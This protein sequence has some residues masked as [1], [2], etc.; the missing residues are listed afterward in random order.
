MITHQI[1]WQGVQDEAVEIL[2]KYIRIN[3]TNPP[4]NEMEAA[5][6]LK[7]IF[8]KEGGEAFLYEPAPHRANLM[9]VIPG[10]MEGRP[11]ILL[12][13][14][15]VVP[16][17]KDKWT[18][19]PFGG[20]MKDGY[21]YGRG[22]I[23]M[24][25][26]GVAELMTILLLKRYQIPLKRDIIFLATADE[27][28]GGKWGVKWMLEREP[29]LK[30]AASVL[31]EGG[32]ILVREDGVLD[33]YEIATAQKVVAQFTLKAYGKTGHGSMPHEDSATVKLIRALN[34]LAEWETPLVI[35]PLVKEYFANLAKVK[36]TQEAKGYQDIEEALHD[37][38]F[39]KAFTANSQYNAMVR[40]TLTPTILKAG[41]KINVIPSEAQAAFDCRLLPGTSS[42]AFFA[43]LRQVMGDEEIKLAL[44][45]EFES[46]PL[47]PSPTSN[48]LYQAINRVAQRNDPGCVVTP[49]LITG[50]TDSR[51]F[52]E[53]GIPCYDFSPFRL[54]QEDMKLV[55]GH[56]ER[57]SIEN[58][59]FASRVIFEIVHE[60]AAG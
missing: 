55:H 10:A 21:I 19:D 36:P 40:N 13:H 53:I 59:G 12:N 41:Q 5:H 29:R 30:E 2:K 44:L 57:I 15:D 48:E 11:L 52:R 17:E 4:G 46:S 9:A 32:C 31:N 23:D 25:G 51:F 43:Q 20:I 35:I 6:Y 16:C 28:V 45:P 58:L 3:T 56:N 8:R 27:E 37:P 1:D 24:K 7:G 34:R 60:V 14:M 18:I 49:F 47:P 22:T 38:A 50:A 33:H 26:N 54:R 42:E 39:V